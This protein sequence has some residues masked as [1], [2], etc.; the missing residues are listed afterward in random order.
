MAGAARVSMRGL[1]ALSPGF[2]GHQPITSQ[3]PR[4]ERVKRRSGESRAMAAASAPGKLILFGEHAVVFG[5]PALS[6]AIDLRTE[7]Y[8]RPHT[9]WLADGMGLD[10]PRYAYVRAATNRAWSGSPPWFEVRSMLPIGSGLG[11]RS[12]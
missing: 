4:E 6:T 3:S 11:S 8:A 7:V 12:E 2:G 10:E 9:S 5:E 1:R